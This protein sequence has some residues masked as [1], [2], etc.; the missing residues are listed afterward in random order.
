MSDIYPNDF[1]ATDP[2]IPPPPSG[3]MTAT[4]QFPGNAPRQRGGRL[5]IALGAIVAI[6]L[7]LLALI[8]VLLPRLTQQ[9][10]AVVVATAFCQ[11]EKNREYVRAY[12][13][14]ADAVQSA[15]P[16][17]AYSLVSQGVDDRQGKITDCT[18]TTANISKDGN[19]AIVH[20]TLTRQVN[21]KKLIDLS[22]A[23]VNG[24]WKINQA[25]DVAIPALATPF[26]FCRDITTLQYN[27][28]Y[29]LL[30]PTLQQ[31]F[32]SG[33]GLKSALAQL[34]Q[35][36]GTVTDCQLQGF[37]LNSDKVSGTVLSGTSFARFQNV[38]TKIAVLTDATGI[39]K[40]DSLT[41][42]VLGNPVKFPLGS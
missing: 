22:L 11:A 17:D 18:V 4:D 34:A 29:M 40:I 25:P 37:N 27:A 26:L 1:T 16:P 19:S 7:V 23:K 5:W 42:D 38:P 14:F 10:G 9:S 24:T 41:F 15:V 36:T 2:L 39:W 30:T 21:G 6:M 20:S 35:V 13:Y 32:G 12:G 33:D 31:S 28:A 3:V 8:A